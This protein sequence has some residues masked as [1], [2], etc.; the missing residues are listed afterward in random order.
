MWT[1]VPFPGTNTGYSVMT[2]WPGTTT[3]DMSRGNSVMAIGHQPITGGAIETN[4]LAQGW[5]GVEFYETKFFA[6]TW[7]RTHDLRVRRP[8]P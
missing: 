7:V 2:E 5:T 4:Y 1:A 8:T 6:H 3:Q